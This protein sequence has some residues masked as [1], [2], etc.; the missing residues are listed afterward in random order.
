MQTIYDSLFKET[1]KTELSKIEVELSNIKEL[2]SA[3]KQGDTSLKSVRNIS[4]QFEEARRNLIKGIAEANTAI[5][6]LSTVSDGFAS[7]AKSLGLKADSVK[8]YNEVQD[9][10]NSMKNFV[11]NYEK[12]LK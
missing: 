2:K 10:I 12:Q 4:T 1:K 3:L 5:K 11:N 6:K 9:K 8:E 7:A